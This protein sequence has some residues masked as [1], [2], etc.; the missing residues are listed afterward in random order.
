VFYVVEPTEENLLE[1]IAYQKDPNRTDYFFGDRLPANSV[2][3]VG[4]ACSGEINFLWIIV[5]QGNTL[6]VPSGW[7][8][9]VW[10]PLDSLVFGG[11]FLHSLNIAMQIRHV[12]TC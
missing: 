11:N 3:K 12:G 10:T 2:Q 9:A 5:E 4:V 8:H 1:F 6:M 7:I